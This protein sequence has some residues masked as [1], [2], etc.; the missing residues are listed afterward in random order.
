MQ[1]ASYF[2]KLFKNKQLPST[3]SLQQNEDNIQVEEEWV[4]VHDEDANSEEHADFIPTL[5]A[6]TETAKES[7]LENH[8]TLANLGEERLFTYNFFNIQ[9]TPSEYEPADLLSTKDSDSFER[10]EHHVVW[11]TNQN[12]EANSIDVGYSTVQESSIGG[13][14]EEIL[15]GNSPSL[16]FLET[17]E[18]RGRNE[19]EDAI[20]LLEQL[21]RIDVLGRNRELIVEESPRRDETKERKWQCEKRPSIPRYSIPFVNSQARF[22]K[23]Q[24]LKSK[25]LKSA[26]KDKT[27]KEAMNSTF[28]SSWNILSCLYA[29]Q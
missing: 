20:A 15:N 8:L 23:G 17:K 6:V 26:K 4:V 3:P 11:G 27:I 1:L 7:A 24:G 18:D 12:K 29:I 21:E 10:V 22:L 13:I 16:D 19:L 9:T 14:G 25:E 5:V 28:P 2:S